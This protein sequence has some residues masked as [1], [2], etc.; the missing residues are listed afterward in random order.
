MSRAQISV[1]SGKFV[2]LD[3]G[4][5]KGKRTP[6]ETG[7][8]NETKVVLTSGV[9]EGDRVILQQRRPQQGGWGR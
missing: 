8:Q 5:L 7:M 9:T 3:D 6:V 4:S 1:S 2:M